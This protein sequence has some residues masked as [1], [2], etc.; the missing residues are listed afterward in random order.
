MERVQQADT[1][2]VSPTAA[3]GLSDAVRA[4]AFAAASAAKDLLLGDAA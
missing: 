2:T 1:V 3:G 4:A